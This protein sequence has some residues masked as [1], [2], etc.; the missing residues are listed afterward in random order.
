VTTWAVVAAAAAAAAQAAP[1][2]GRGKLFW[3]GIAIGVTGATLAT[4]ALTSLRVESR[5]AGNSP[6]G[7]YRECVARATANPVY[8]TSDCNALKGANEKL[9]WSG[10]VLGAVG[11]ALVIGGLN[12]HAQI[13]PAGL[14]VTHRIRF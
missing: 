3:P 13:T 9:M 1:A 11:G 12:T 7:L 5:S 6:D 14:R 10:V 4:L 2:G 8:A